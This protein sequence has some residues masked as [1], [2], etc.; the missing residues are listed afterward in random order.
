[1]NEARVAQTATL[2]NN[3]KVLVAGGASITRYLSSAELYDPASGTFSPTGRM[4]TGREYATATLLNDGRVLIAGGVGQVGNHGDSLASAEIYDPAS[5]KF[6]TVGS[7]AH[8]RFGHTV[9][10]LEDHTVLVAGGLDTR[11]Q[12]VGRFLQSAEIF[13]PGTLS[14]S[15][16]SNMIRRR[17][18][19]AASLLPD[20]T[21]L[22]TGGSVDGLTITNSAEL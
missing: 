14:F 10:L 13:D 2:L 3:G 6:T 7:M 9:V 4:S 8:S 5:A 11:R 17:F 19:H 21:V 1:M 20:G 16:T 15:S 12:G 22:I 18:N